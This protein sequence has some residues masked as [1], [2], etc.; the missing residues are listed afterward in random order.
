[1]VFQA[2]EESA[3][4]LLTPCAAPPITL[5][6][7]W[8]TNPG[9]KKKKI[10][11]IKPAAALPRQYKNFKPEDRITLVMCVRHLGFNQQYNRAIIYTLPL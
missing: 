3:G 6:S 8:E 4:F 10:E 5:Y 1:M 11:C 7:A 2:R 9:K